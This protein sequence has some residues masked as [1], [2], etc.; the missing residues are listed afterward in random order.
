MVKSLIIPLG[1]ELHISQDVVL[2]AIDKV[3]FTTYY[4]G[5]ESPVNYIYTRALHMHINLIA[6]MVFLS[7]YHISK[8]P[9]SNNIT[10]VNQS[11]II[12]RPQQIPFFLHAGTVF[13]Q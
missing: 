6:I 12:I 4:S 5:K 11:I 1:Y 9:N 8:E 2:R 13:A 3:G 7:S 10:L